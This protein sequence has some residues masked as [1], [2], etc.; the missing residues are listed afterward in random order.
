VWN[1][2]TIL[3]LISILGL[4]SSGVYAATNLN[5]DVDELKQWQTGHDAYH[6]ERIAEVKLLEGRAE[7][8][9]R[10]LENQTRKIDQIEYRLNTVEKSYIDAVAA[11]KELQ[12]SITQQ[13]V[14]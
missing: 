7:E 5:R 14:E 1:F 13:A 12:T 8:R 3:Q 9:W 11:V 10:S 4:L 6:K 2:N